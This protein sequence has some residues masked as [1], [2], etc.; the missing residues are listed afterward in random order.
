MP[1]HEWHGEQGFLSYPPELNGKMGREGK[2][3]MQAAVV[4]YVNLRRGAIDVFQAY[5]FDAR[6]AQPEIVSRPAA[7]AEM[8]KFAVLEKDTPKKGYDGPECRAEATTGPAPNGIEF[9]LGI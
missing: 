3:V 8:L 9:G 4:C 2:N 1:T 7:H 6:A 5:D